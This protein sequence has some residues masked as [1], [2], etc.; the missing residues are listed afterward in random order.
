M[1]DFTQQNHT[2]PRAILTI[3]TSSKGNLRFGAQSLVT[4][5]TGLNVLMLPILESRVGGYTNL[6]RNSFGFRVC[7][8]HLSNQWKPKPPT[9]MILVTMDFTENISC[10]FYK[11]FTELQIQ[12]YR[13]PQNKTYKPMRQEQELTS[14]PR[15]L[16][17]TNKGN[18]RKP[19]FGGLKF[20]APKIEVTSNTFFQ[21]A[22]NS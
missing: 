17:A 19:S 12:R 3:F 22:A 10:S 4:S 8:S 20:S 14:D 9:G 2:K 7:W 15:V 18:I 21:V 5:M 13:Y 11:H 1:D 6:S 16:I